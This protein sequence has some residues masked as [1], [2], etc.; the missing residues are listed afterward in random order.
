M[1]TSQSRCLQDE[2]GAQERPF[3][4]HQLRFPSGN[5]W[6]WREWLWTGPSHCC[7]P[8]HLRVCRSAGR[9]VSYSPAPRPGPEIT[10]Y[11]C[12]GKPTSS[13]PTSAEVGEGIAGIIATFRPSYALHFNHVV[14]RQSGNSVGAR[15]QIAVLNGEG[16]G[17]GCRQELPFLSLHR[18]GNSCQQQS[19]GDQDACVFHWSFSFFKVPVNP[20]DSWHIASCSV[21]RS[22]FCVAALL[23]SVSCVFC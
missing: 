13:A 14:R 22:M 16:K 12:D 6:H 21:Q 19:G 3:P 15:R 1:R 10:H 17:N 11:R 9:D 7:G 2:T 23:L 8:T 4:R 5:R 20:A 18:N